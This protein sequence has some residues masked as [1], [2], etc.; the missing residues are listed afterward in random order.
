MMG[1]EEST[2]RQKKTRIR[3]EIIQFADKT[4]E[5]HV[6]DIVFLPRSHPQ[7]VNVDSILSALRAPLKIRLGERI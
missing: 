1:E 4:I 7:L 6:E 3:I 2:K 5:V